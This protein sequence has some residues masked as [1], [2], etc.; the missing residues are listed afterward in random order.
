MVF[1]KQRGRDPKDKLYCELG[2]LLDILARERDIRGPYAIAEYLKD[3]NA[4]NTSGQAISKYMYGHS[5]P[6]PSFITVFAEA[7]EL[8]RQERSE[9]AWTYAYGSRPRNEGFS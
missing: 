5:W 7:F 4:Y 2:K 6:K 9:L 3:S 1:I 8:S